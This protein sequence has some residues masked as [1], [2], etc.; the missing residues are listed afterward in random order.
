MVGL[1]S[2]AVTENK[3]VIKKTGFRATDHSCSMC[4]KLDDD[5]M[6]LCNKCDLW[7]H[8]ICRPTQL[9]LYQYYWL[10]NFSHTQ[11]CQRCTTVPNDF[12]EMATHHVS[13]MESVCDQ[14][15]IGTSRSRVDQP[16]LGI[17]IYAYLFCQNH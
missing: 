1:Q 11:T 16:D 15:Q 6:I 7:I 13:S 4:A 3:N 8:M 14:K 17:Y 2:T 10:A 9:P 5:M 12:E